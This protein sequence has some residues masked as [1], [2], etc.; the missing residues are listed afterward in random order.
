M[1]QE[2]PKE[3]IEAIEQERSR[4][5]RIVRE[6]IGEC[7]QLHSHLLVR[8]ANRIASGDQTKNPGDSGLDK[9]AGGMSDAN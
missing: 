9:S 2:P 1:S 6:S 5:V 4:C 7:D 8:I 3:V